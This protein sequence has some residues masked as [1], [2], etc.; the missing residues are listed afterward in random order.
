MKGILSQDEDTLF[1]S[2][3]KSDSARSWSYDGTRIVFTCDGIVYVSDWNGSPLAITADSLECRNAVSSPLD[4]RIAFE[5]DADGTSQIYTTTL[6]IGGLQKLTSDPISAT[7]PSWRS[8]GGKIAYTG[9][10]GIHIMN[11]DGSG[12]TQTTFSP[13]DFAPRWSPQGDKLLYQ[14]T[15][16]GNNELFLI[17]SDGSG[18]VNVTQ[19]NAYDSQGAWSL[20]GDAIVFVS[21]KDH[22][23]PDEYGIPDSHTDLYVFTLATGL[24]SRFTTDSYAASPTFATQTH[25]VFTDGGNL[26]VYNMASEEVDWLFLPSR[27]ASVFAMSPGPLR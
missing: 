1:A 3:I 24:I 22:L 10:Q 27:Y 18:E 26:K 12:N 20:N 11:S 21:N 2:L 19:S 17:N 9:S 6:P 5:S 7:F 14:S 16:T 23:V 8:D 15:R 25:I 4:P 13:A